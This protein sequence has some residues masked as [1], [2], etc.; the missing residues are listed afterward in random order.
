[1][2]YLKTLLVSLLALV[3]TSAFA[4]TWTGNE[5]ADG[6]FYL[7]NVGTGKWL[8]GGNNWGTK[9]SLTETGGYDVDLALS[10]GAY[11]IKTK[12][13]TNNKANGPGYLGSNG[14]VDGE[15]PYGWTFTQVKTADGTAYLIS[16]ADGKN[17][18]Y[19]GTGTALEVLAT[20]DANA[21]WMLVSKADRDA[22]LENA[23]V[24]SPV[25][26]TYY[27]Q[28]PNFNR[29]NDIRRRAWSM[30]ASNQNLCGGANDNTCAESW[31][32]SFTLTQ[33]LAV[34]NGRY[35]LKAQ[36]ALTEYTQTGADLPVIYANDVTA[37]FP[38]MAEGESSM[39]TMSNQ[40]TAGKY[41]VGPLTVDVTSGS[42]SIGAKGTRTDTWCIWDNFRLSYLG[43][44]PI[45]EELIAKANEL[46][47]TL[48]E[49]NA[50]ALQEAIDAAQAVLDNEESTNSEIEE[51]VAALQDAYDTA[52]AENIA[53]KLAADVLNQ[54]PYVLFPEDFNWD[55]EREYKVYKNNN[56][57]YQL[58]SR[59]AVAAL[60]KLLDFAE[61]DDKTKEAIKARLAE[62]G[63]EEDLDEM[64]A[65][66]LTK[67]A[68]LVVETHGV[69]AALGEQG[70]PNYSR[71]YN[72][73]EKAGEDV[74]DFLDVLLYGSSEG[75]LI[76]VTPY[77]DGTISGNQWSS[78]DGF[79]T[80]TNL[81]GN[82]ITTSDPYYPW[83][84][85]VQAGEDWKIQ[86]NVEGVSLYALGFNAYGVT[87]KVDDGELQASYDYYTEYNF[88]VRG[89]SEAIVH[90]DEVWYPEVD[91]DVYFK[92]YLEDTRDPWVARGVERTLSDIY[93]MLHDYFD[94][95]W[96]FDANYTAHIADP[97]LTEGGDAWE[98]T[99]GGILSNEPLTDSEG[100]TEYPYFDANTWNESGTMEVD[101]H[102]TIMLP[103]GRYMLTAA[104]RAS[105]NTK[106][107][108]Q[109]SH[110]GLDF[111]STVWEGPF[112]EPGAQDPQ[113]YFQLY[114]TTYEGVTVA[115]SFLDLV[116]A[117]GGIFNNGWNDASVFFTMPSN[118]EVTIGVRAATNVKERWA[119]ATRF[120]LTRLGDATL[121]LNE[122]ETL[123][124]ELNWDVI[125]NEIG[126]YAPTDFLLKK[127]MQAGNWY[128]IAL[129]GD[130]STQQLITQ[131][132]EGTLLALPVEVTDYNE[133]GTEKVVNFVEYDPMQWVV[134][135]NIFGDYVEGIMANVPFLI[136]PA[137]T[138]ESNRYLFK[139]I[140]STETRSV[141]EDGM[142][143]WGAL[144][145]YP[146]GD[147]FEVG[148]AGDIKF[149]PNYVNG[150]NFENGYTIEF[151]DTLKAYTASLVGDGTDVVAVLLYN[152]DDEGYLAMDHPYDILLQQF[153][154]AI[155]LG[156]QKAEWYPGIPAAMTKILTTIPRVVYVADAVEAMKAYKSAIVEAEKAYEPSKK[157]HALVEEAEALMAQDHI[158]LVEG[159]DANF[160]AV[161]DEIVKRFDTLTTADA[162]V[163]LN[164][165]LAKAFEEYK[166]QIELVGLIESGN[167]YLQN[168]GSGKFFGAAN[169]WGTRSSLVKHAEVVTFAKLDDGTYTLESRYTNGGTSYYLGPNYFVD[170]GNPMPLTITPLGGNVYSIMATGDAGTGYL[171]WDGSTTEVNGALAD[172][173]SANAKWII[174]SEE[175]MLA[176]LAEAAVENPLDA[177]FLVKDPN[178]SRNHRDK[179]TWVVEAANSNLAGGD[180]TNMCA[181]SW[182]SA[183]TVSQEVTVPNGVYRID[184]QAAL[185]D[186]ANAY[187]GADY[188]V[189]FANEESTPF[190]EM[191]EADRATSMTQLS[192]SFTAGKYQVQPL[193]IKVTDGKITLGVR[194][195]RTDTWAIWDNFELTFF[196]DVAIED[197]KTAVAG[198]GETT[199]IN[200]IN[201]ADQNNVIYNING[202]R[203]NS[204]S[205]KGVYIVNGKKV[206]VK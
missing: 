189:V 192:G 203:V 106:N 179:S 61:A 81:S 111:T 201:A 115:K 102:Q 38:A 182:Q 7:Y 134:L 80:I 100:S 158:E 28:D 88:D 133:D 62:L 21:Q 140:T 55:A 56:G 150:K 173:K 49:T 160:K 74:D 186:Y 113:N 164:E 175:D 146:D 27:I 205:Q 163:A 194:G 176:G 131:F 85:T 109:R 125:G 48:N 200:D 65:D 43:M 130:I 14:F 22:A 6:T 108:K 159:A 91:P 183:F 82:D 104:G 137:Q 199:G 15:N 126:A 197:V 170:N 37:P 138:K 206:T 188:P 198:S 145:L 124:H 41:E 127:E 35:Q 92:V 191:E 135:N 195:T 54:V 72:A 86:S 139:D 171:G 64:L 67:Y 119:S 71:M 18:A 99:W 11:T 13:R 169:S 53:K 168:V 36:A 94:G 152:I 77:D 39:T 121:Y 4:Q 151:N 180:N 73:I 23:K 44:A 32:S 93:E 136:K 58:A 120:R 122:D 40:F 187:D 70:D 25:D 46:M 89:N 147:W 16:T 178:F 185:T 196:G 31:R 66:A 118:G 153:Y 155:D 114:A 117:K 103:P 29:Y 142:W 129:P 57:Q 177:T 184:A 148:D 5:V 83:Y 75:Q 144:S 59:I 132:G 149:Y 98:S 165:E 63:V 79:V 202:V 161:L 51:A 204:M 190:I 90:I 10:S 181:E 116:G 8:T 60:V 166:A 105:Q 174:T 76:E 20:T 24:A 193:I 162:V 84:Y 172:A 167:Y 19:P 112:T 78:A 30:Q 34:P 157:F 26:A 128:S 143:S 45:L 141:F 154:E 1:M 2:R 47:P 12:T 17:L 96:G 87:F 50:A 9:A 156:Q 52:D 3:G 123:T 69:G 33:A 97:D 68:R 101:A 42:L 95:Y 110:A 107:E